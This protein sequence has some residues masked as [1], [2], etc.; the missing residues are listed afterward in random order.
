MVCSTLK[1]NRKDVLIMRD[2]YNIL[3]TIILQEIDQKQTVVVYPFGK[4]GLLAKQILVSRYGMQGII[5][6][7][8][9][10]KYNSEIIDINKYEELDSDSKTIILCASDVDLNRSLIKD[11]K[12][13]NLNSKIR[14]ILE[15]PAFFRPEKKTYFEQ[16]KKLC[17]VKKVIGHELI[18]IG[19]GM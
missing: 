16:I 14:N 11:L 6:D 10:V 9:L 19:G 17:A 12:E 5:I 18:R 15:V 4:I 2:Y 1:R 7:N 13:R 3:N 8:N